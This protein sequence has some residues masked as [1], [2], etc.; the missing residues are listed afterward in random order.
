MS[1]VSQRE[2]KQVGDFVFSQSKT[3]VNRE[4]IYKHPLGGFRYCKLNMMG[5]PTK[6][7]I[8]ENYLGDVRHG[9]TYTFTDKR[10]Y[11]KHYYYYGTRIP[12]KVMKL[13]NYEEDKIELYLSLKSL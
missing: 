9:Y 12:D 8:I 1:H 6:A 10:N 7:Y 5:K 4:I 2:R 13:V 11:L 3:G